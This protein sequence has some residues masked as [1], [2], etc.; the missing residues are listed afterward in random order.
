M[1]SCKCPSLDLIWP[2]FTF[3]SRNYF[4]GKYSRYRLTR[5]FVS[6][7]LNPVRDSSSPVF[8][9]WHEILI[10]RDI[11]GIKC[12]VIVWAVARAT[13]FAKGPARISCVSVKPLEL[14]TIIANV[15]TFSRWR[16]KKCHVPRRLFKAMTDIMFVSRSE[17]QIKKNDSCIDGKLWLIFLSH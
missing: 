1:H 10:K 8:H 5:P 13:R 9:S 16:K 12:A 3:L 6:L 14:A 4:F 11:K 15:I 7:L 17:G 2:L